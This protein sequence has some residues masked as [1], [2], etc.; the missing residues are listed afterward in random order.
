MFPPVVLTVLTIF[1]GVVSPLATLVAEL[2]HPKLV[3]PLAGVLLT[4]TNVTVPKELPPLVPSSMVL[5]PEGLAAEGV[6]LYDLL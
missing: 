2:F 3:Q 1:E 5:V 6:I 4:G